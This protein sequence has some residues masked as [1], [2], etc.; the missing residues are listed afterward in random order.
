VPAGRW[1]DRHRRR[2]ASLANGSEIEIP[3]E[4]A[5]RWGNGW[6]NVA[7]SRCGRVEG[8]VECLEEEG[9]HPH[10]GSTGG[11]YPREFGVVAKPA[12]GCIDRA[13]FVGDDPN[14]ILQGLKRCQGH[15]RDRSPGLE[16]G[17]GK[18]GAHEPPETTVGWLLSDGATNE[19][20]PDDW[21]EELVEEATEGLPE[22]A[23][24]EPW[25]PEARW[26]AARPAKA[27]VAT[28][29]RIPVVRVIR[30]TRARLRSRSVAE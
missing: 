5:E 2:L 27:A 9:T 25:D 8:D 30:F 6:I 17:G 4:S 14:R 21:L 22:P 28:A 12:T 29:A 1:S 18:S 3:A 16:D 20:S 13:N 10:R 26:V 23:L 19:S 24:E 15:L 11:F 7:V